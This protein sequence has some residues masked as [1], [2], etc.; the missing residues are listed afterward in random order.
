[1]GNIMRAAG[2]YMTK[3]EYEDFTKTGRIKAL[4]KELS[5]STG[6]VGS[7]CTHVTRMIVQLM[8]NVSLPL[9]CQG[10]HLGGARS[11]T[12]LRSGSCG[13]F[14]QKGARYHRP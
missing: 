12:L 7:P 2:A 5:L 4:I 3:L 8:M 1:M 6:A 14:L 13:I 11:E 10:R 9:V